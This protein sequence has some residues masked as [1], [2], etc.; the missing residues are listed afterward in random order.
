MP[1]LFISYRR[2]DSEGYVGRLYDR[3]TDHFPADDLFLDVESIGPGE[4]FVRKLADEVAAC[5]VLLAVIGPDWATITDETGARRLTQENDFVRIEIASALQQDKTII[6]VLVGQAKMPAGAEL[7]DDLK[8]LARRNALAL[9]HASFTDDVERLIEAIKASAPAHPALKP[10]ADADTHREKAAALKAL[11][12]ALVNAK[13]APLYQHRVTNGLYPVLGAGNPDANLFF[14]GESPGKYEAEAGQPFVGPSGE[15]LD[16]LL[17]GI[18]L[19]REDVYLSNIIL[20]MP[21]EK[22][23]PNAAEIAYY[24]GFVDRLLAIIEPVVIVPLGR[25]AMTHV[26]RKF[27]LPHKGRTISKLHGTVFEAQAPQGGP[28]FIV[29]LFH[30]AVLLYTASKKPILRADFEQLRPFV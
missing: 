9:R 25:F 19:R 30:P 1:R 22:R 17:A 10:P 2:Q 21:E 14:L 29:P 27:G 5:D 7:P 18:G 24:A 11:R 12:K 16:D 13:D 8:P 4:D 26:L 15:I 28:L 23:S 3:L 20:D 6:P